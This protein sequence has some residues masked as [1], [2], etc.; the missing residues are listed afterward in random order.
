MTDQQDRE[1]KIKK[2]IEKCV[3]EHWKNTNTVLYLS[4]LGV[5]L[6]NNQMLLSES[7]RCFLDKHR[8]VN[9]VQF[10]GITQKV[11]AIPLEIIVPPDPAD[12]K[13]LFKK[14]TTTS[15]VRNKKIYTQDFWRAFTTPIEGRSRYVVI[16]EAGNITVSSERPGGE[17]DMVYEISESDLKN[18]MS[19]KT[20]SERVKAIHS[21]IEAWLKRNS[22]SCN[23]F[24]ESKSSK[25]CGSGHNR[26]AKF[27]T[28]F[29]DIPSDDLARIHIPLDVFLK[30]VAKKYD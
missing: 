2:F 16:H 26:L 27:L 10:P 1:S 17:A 6:K 21:A 3:C 22:L 28:A 13:E 19:Y 14:N 18:D 8:I 7:L 23:D 12:V 20:N 9:V 15:G 4:L 24:L 29:D 5:E 30:L 11:G 25:R